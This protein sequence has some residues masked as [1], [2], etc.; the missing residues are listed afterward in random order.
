MGEGRGGEWER[1][2]DDEGRLERGV[3]AGNHAE[4]WGFNYDPT[5]AGRYGSPRGPAVRI[6]DV[7]L[8]DGARR[9]VLVIMCLSIRRESRLEWTS[10]LSPVIGPLLL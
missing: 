5:G 7:K 1:G 2:E 10:A 9:F 4:R 6:L 3:T 8:R